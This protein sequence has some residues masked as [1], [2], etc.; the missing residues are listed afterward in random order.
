MTNL[1]PYT[2]FNLLKNSPLEFFKLQQL[3]LLK[4]IS[5]TNKNIFEQQFDYY[6]KKQKILFKKKLLEDKNELQTILEN[7]SSPL[8]ELL[9]DAIISV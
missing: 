8:H 1:K 3:L 4:G 2:H 6:I 5:D 7:L 9:G